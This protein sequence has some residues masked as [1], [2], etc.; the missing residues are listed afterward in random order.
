MGTCGIMELKGQGGIIN[1]GKLVI[2]SIPYIQSIRTAT[3]DRPKIHCMKMEAFTEYPMP[4]YGVLQNTVGFRRSDRVKIV[5][6]DHRPAEVKSTE[7]E[8]DCSILPRAMLP[9]F[10]CHFFSL[11]P[12]ECSVED[13]CWLAKIKRWMLTP[14]RHRSWTFLFLQFFYRADS[15]F[16]VACLGTHACTIPLYGSRVIL[17]TGDGKDASCS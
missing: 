9:W 15:L 4:L 5:H 14:Y 13:S 6:T 17:H 3:K 11:C 10:I 12:P 2:L 16:C 1:D 8:W 7:P